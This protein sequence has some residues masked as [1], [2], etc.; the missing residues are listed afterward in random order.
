MPEDITAIE[1]R[2]EE[3]V[4][5]DIDL[6]RRLVAL[7]EKHHLSQADVATRMGVTQ[8]T[9][10]SFER[11]DANP[12]LST[13]RRYALAVDALV[14]HRVRD[15]CANHSVTA[16]NAIIDSSQFVWSKAPEFQWASPAFASQNGS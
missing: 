5:N 12:R 16:F 7:R 4:E 2:A 6:L 10:S 14:E 8:P 11:Y 13:I 15:D 3:L 9:V 1:A